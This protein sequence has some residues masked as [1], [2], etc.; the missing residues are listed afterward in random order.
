MKFK[1][2]LSTL[3]ALGLTASFLAG[4]NVGGNTVKYD[5]NR[6]QLF[7]G[8][9][10]GGIGDEWCYAFKARFEEAYKEV[11]YE[12]GKTGVEVIIDKSKSVGG[13]SIGTSLDTLP[14]EVYFTEV[15]YYRDL[16]ANNALAD[17]TDIV[18]GNLSAYGESESIENKLTENYA[19]YL[20][21]NEKYYALPYYEDTYACYYDKDMFKK[22]SFYLAA[23]TEDDTY[24]AAYE[25]VDGEKY[26]EFTDGSVELSA[27]ADGV[28]A[29][30][31]DGL[32]ATVEQFLALCSTMA[33]NGV[34]PITF[35]GSSSYYITRWLKALSV[36]L[37]GEER[38]RMQY[39][40]NGVND[41]IV[42]SVNADGTVTLMEPQTITNENGYLTYYDAGRY[43]ALKLWEELVNNDYLY[44][45]TKG[46]YSHLQAQ[47]D[48][49]LGSYKSVPNSV[50][51]IGMLIDGSWW[52]NESKTFFGSMVNQ[53]YGK[54]AARDKRNFGVMPMPKLNDAQIGDDAM[55]VNTNL[56]LAFIS[57]DVEGK[58][59]E[60]AKAFLQFCYTDESLREFTRIVNMP[61]SVEYELTTDDKNQM[62][63]YGKSLVQLTAE[64]TKIYP[65][66]S[67]SV[68][69]NNTSA[70]SVDAGWDTIVKGTKYPSVKNYFYNDT[71]SSSLRTAKTYFDGFKVN[72]SAEQW[73]N[74]YSA[75]F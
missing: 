8:V 20:S 50:Q 6:T 66:S 12:E 18:T 65:Y 57:S 42:E 53:G 28:K 21:V 51:K 62:T 32:P 59:L 7:V 47:Q 63:T 34:K 26:F 56:P 72:Y 25:L 5:P 67:N 73:R 10:D 30:E 2:S 43:Y 49:I 11:S 46:T 35:S 36:S 27:G 64:K 37:M 33:E 70:F 55:L 44:S 24:P 71:I 45:K 74:A 58:Q 54:D 39:N 60:L 14:Y 41:S 68:Y 16:V 13:N 40:F 69:T 17:I 75:N 19:D 29:T 61:I 22:Y 4:C 31:D 48:F 15:V 1:R 23:N 9:V 52:E 3:M 38:A